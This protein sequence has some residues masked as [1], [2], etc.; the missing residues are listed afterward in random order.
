LFI[1]I[2]CRSQAQPQYFRLKPLEGYFIDER[3]SLKDGMNFFV[4]S[5][6]KKV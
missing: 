5:D 1:S 4:I 3:I 2:A 6:R